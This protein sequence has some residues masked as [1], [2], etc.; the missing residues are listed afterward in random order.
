[1]IKIVL[2]EKDFDYEIQ[3]LVNSF[4]PGQKSKVVMY[5][6]DNVEDADIVININFNMNEISV[7]VKSDKINTVR[8]EK[9]T[10]EQDYHK[11]EG[12]TT[13]P[14]RTY[15][16]NILKKLIYTELSGIND[17]ELP[18]GAAPPLSA[19]KQFGHITRLGF[20]VSNS[21]PHLMHLFTY[22]IQAS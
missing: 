5:G 18:D 4:F 1:M 10:G 21:A 3:A 16:K 7:A 22:I 15:Y 6:N 2:S 17:E 20:F 12:K 19:Y 9:V 13:H 8:T 14:Y 11:H